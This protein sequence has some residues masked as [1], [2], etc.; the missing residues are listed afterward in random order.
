MNGTLLA[1]QLIKSEDVD[2]DGEIFHVRLFVQDGG[3]A[4]K[5]HAESKQS[6]RKWD[7]NSDT[8]TARDAKHSNV[9]IY[10]EVWAQVIDDVRNKLDLPLELRG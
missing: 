4:I 6:D 2:V 10:E 7:V 1:L 5:A 3:G 8:D 9:D